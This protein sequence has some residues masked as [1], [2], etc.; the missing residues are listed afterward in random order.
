MKANVL[1]SLP[2]SA[3][4][5]KPE[6]YKTSIM[7]KFFSAVAVFLFGGVFAFGQGM[8]KKA[9]VEGQIFY[10]IEGNKLRIEAYCEN[11]SDKSLELTYKMKIAQTDARNNS[12]SNSQGGRKELAALESKTLSSSSFSWREGSRFTITLD[13]YHKKKLLDSDTLELSATEE[14]EGGAEE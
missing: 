8:G 1:R 14:S 5:Y 2:V 7:C 3:G 13:I 4:Y 10:E 6:N 12:V 9:T 11:L